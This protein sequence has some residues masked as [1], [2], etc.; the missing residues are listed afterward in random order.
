MLNTN[1]RIKDFYNLQGYYLRLH[2]TNQQLS[3]ISYNSNL[4][5]GIKYELQINSEDIKKNDKLKNLTVLG[6]YELINNKIKENKIIIKGEQNQ[7]ILSLLENKESNPNK[8]IQI[9]LLKNN[10]IFSSEYEN[11]I[12]NVIMN[13]KEENR[14]MRNEINE[15]RNLLKISNNDNNISASNNKRVT[16]EVRKINTQQMN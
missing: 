16:A 5:D 9:C 13:L 1:E 7:V 10:K 8:D 14:N 3:L 12:A 15:I 6:L 4:L 11:V 2:L